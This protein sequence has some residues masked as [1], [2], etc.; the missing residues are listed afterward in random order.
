MINDRW[1]GAMMRA[2]DPSLIIERIPTGILSIDTT[3]SGGFAR[4]RHVEIFGGYNVG[5]TYTTYRL[6]ATTQAAGGRCAFIDVEGTFDPEFATNCG[7]D[8]E[9]LDF[10]QQEHGN[11]VIDFME[12]LLRSRLYDVIVLDSIAALLPKAEL[13]AD[14]EAGSYGTA[15]AKLMSAA[16]RR[17]TAANRR[18]VLVYI[19]QTREAIG[20]I[21]AKRSVT[22]GGRAMAF[23]AGT[24][25][26]MVRTENIKRKGQVLDPEKGEYAEKDVVKGHRVLVRVEKDKT[27][28]AHQHATTSFV[29]DYDLGGIDPVEDLVYCGRVRGLVHKSGNSWWL[30]GY[31]DE[32]Q[33]SRAKFKGWLRRNVAVAEE[34]EEL[35]RTGEASE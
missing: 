25:L 11:R 5:K 16:L 18:T 22:S 4:G 21:F 27:G 28:S 29:F 26:E 35:I 3:L 10:H 19:N 32:K 34:L 1:P 15:Q 20:S 14:M 17:L 31:E 7:V 13:E 8:I 6:I 24:R 9:E 23:Y 30:N 33:P 2:S 12:T